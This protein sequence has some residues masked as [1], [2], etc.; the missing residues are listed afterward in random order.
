MLNLRA[1]A[2][3]LSSKI[4]KTQR[5]IFNQLNNFE[6]PN[7]QVAALHGKHEDLINQ[8]TAPQMQQRNYYVDLDPRLKKLETY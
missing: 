2:D 1:E 5:A 6:Q 4:L 7:R 3:L 8:V